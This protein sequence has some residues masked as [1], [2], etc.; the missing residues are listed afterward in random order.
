MARTKKIQNIT[1]DAHNDVHTTE[2]EA[3]AT[4]HITLVTD[5]FG[6]ADLNGLRDKLNEVIKR[7][8]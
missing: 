8:A 4:A 5:D 1:Q 7:I 3:I 6:R 2:V